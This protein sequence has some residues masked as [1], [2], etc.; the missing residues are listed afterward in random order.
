MPRPSERPASGSRLGPSTMSAMTSTTSISGTPM[1]DIMRGR[2]RSRGRSSAD[3]EAG[4]A[5][6][7]EDRL[8]R[9]AL[10]EGAVD[11]D[12]RRRLVGEGAAAVE[13]GGGGRV[14]RLD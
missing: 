1:P 10:V 2:S 8:H 9:L 6:R 11:G 13:H 12:R 4:G 14:A 3:D 7:L 5:D